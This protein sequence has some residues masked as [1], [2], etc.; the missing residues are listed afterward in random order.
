MCSSDLQVLG[1]LKARLRKCNG[2]K[3]A[4]MSG[5]GSTV[6]ALLEEG[7]PAGPLEEAIREEVGAEVDCIWTRLAP[8]LTPL[9][10]PVQHLPLPPRDV[11]F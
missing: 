6:F 7:A 11:A 9:G 8:G 2:V 5:S 1:H 4:L 10:I 3:A